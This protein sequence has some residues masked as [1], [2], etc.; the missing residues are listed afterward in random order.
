VTSSW[1][2]LGKESIGIQKQ[3]LD[4]YILSATKQNRHHQC[5][6]ES[7]F[8]SIDKSIAR[9]FQDSQVVMIRGVGDDFV[10]NGQRHEERL[11][12]LKDERGPRRGARMWS[13]VYWSRSRRRSF[14]CPD[15]SITCVVIISACQAPAVPLTQH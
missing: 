3:V 15:A 8:Y 2:L 13:G 5:M 14:K 12:V 7:H 10:E 6:G 11:Y 9:S 4:I 1:N